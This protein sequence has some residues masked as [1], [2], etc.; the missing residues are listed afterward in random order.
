MRVSILL[1]LVAWLT[2]VGA[3]VRADMADALAAFDAGDYASAFQEW[4]V[5]AQA[6]EAEAQVALAG[7]YLAGQ[8]TR[9]DAAEALRWYRLAAD[10][11][12]R[13]YILHTVHRQVD[14]PRQE[15]FLYFFNKNTLAGQL[16]DRRI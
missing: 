9:A 13:R 12:F 15:F 10:R 16:T 3:S 6:G 4:H 14:I 11:E 8:G 1:P 7:L 2:V 5:L